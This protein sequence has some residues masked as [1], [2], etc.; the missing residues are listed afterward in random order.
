MARLGGPVTL[1]HTTEP[2]SRSECPPTAA[3]SGGQEGER[4]E[5]GEPSNRDA[6]AHAPRRPRLTRAPRARA[7]QVFLRELASL[8]TR[9]ES[10][11]AAANATLRCRAAGGRR[12]E[13]SVRPAPSRRPDPPFSSLLSLASSPLAPPGMDPSTLYSSIALVPVAA[14]ALAPAAPVVAIAV[15]IAL[16]WSHLRHTLEVGR[17][18]RILLV[19]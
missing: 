12:D 3:A 17:T 7:L 18:T 8:K 11:A 9:S 5:R 10:A 1:V 19:F 16:V 14:Y 4:R 15:L 6:R 2:A 13:R